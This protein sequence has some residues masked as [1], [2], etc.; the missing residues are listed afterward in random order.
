[1][2]IRDRLLPGEFDYRIESFGGSSNASTGYDDSHYYVLIPPDNFR[3]S[4]SLLTNLV[5]LPK[6]DR[7]EFEKEKL[8]VI[9]EI[10]Q[11]NDQP[12]ELLFNLF[13]KKS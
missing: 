2:C 10:K 6:I 3:E 5:L 7:N 11:Q 12:D 4:L 13:L 8:V 1:M 9:E